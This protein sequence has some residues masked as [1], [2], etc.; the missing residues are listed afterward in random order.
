MRWDER[1]SDLSR[2]V[3]RAVLR[4]SLENP[5][6]PMRLWQ[7]YQAVPDLKP[8]LSVLERL[9]LTKRVLEHALR[10]TSTRADPANLLD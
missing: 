5:A 2:A 9:P 3:Q 4:L 8:K 1:D 6:K 7:I 10:Q